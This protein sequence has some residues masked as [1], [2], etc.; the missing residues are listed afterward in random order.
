MKGRGSS[1]AGVLQQQP[2]SGLS[3]STS[4]PGRFSSCPSR[5]KAIDQWS[6]QVQLR[7]YTSVH[8]LCTQ[9]PLP[10][11]NTQ[12]AAGGQWRGYCRTRQGCSHPSLVWCTPF[13]AQP[14]WA[15]S[16]RT[17]SHPSRPLPSLTAPTQLTLVA[18][19]LVRGWVVKWR[20]L[21]DCAS[22]GFEAPHAC[23]CAETRDVGEREIPCF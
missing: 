15:G 10:N 17:R 7:N 5:K 18:F 19:S 14:G 13:S 9:Y 3:G 11:N 6:K 12:G 16:V 2:R 22:H 21:P 20:L 23:P 1:E 4:P 8:I